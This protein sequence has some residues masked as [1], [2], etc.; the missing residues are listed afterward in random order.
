MTEKRKADVLDTTSEDLATRVKQ[1]VAS[2]SFADPKDDLAFK[3]LLGNNEYTDIPI[4]FLNTLLDFEGDNKI[5]EL[6]SLS[7]DLQKFSLSA[8][9]SAVDIKCRTSA[10][11][12]IAIEMQKRY[13]D[14]FLTRMQTYMS[15][16]TMGQVK[17]GE[18]AKYHKKLKDT[19]ILVIA[20]ENVFKYQDVVFKDDQEDDLYEKTVVPCIKGLGQEVPGNKFHWKF[21]ELDRFA[22]YME[23]KKKGAECTLKEQWLDFFLKCPT[24]KSI[25]TDVDPVIQNAYKVMEEILKDPEKY[26]EYISVKLREAEHEEEIEKNRAEGKAEGRAEGRAEG[27]AEGRAE[28]ELK[29]KVE[30][31]YNALTIPLQHEILMKLFAAAFNEEKIL[32]AE[33][34]I[35]EHPTNH[36]LDD[37]SKLLL[38][39]TLSEGEHSEGM[40]LS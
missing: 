4:K 19:Y 8:I 36:S 13:K 23:Q 28:G 1:E 9:S 15:L 29:G 17:K 14:Y 11:Q 27:K 20:K 18:S 38:G 7:V 34:Y 31:F 21:F 24:M 30:D 26:A 6:V 25:P 40:A 39:K 37:V 5:T 16:L 35:S 10:G 33:K 32:A 22:K 2:L 3:I 12:I